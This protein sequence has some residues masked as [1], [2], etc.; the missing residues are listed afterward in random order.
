VFL[1]IAQDPA[2]YR[3]LMPISLV[4]KAFGLAVVVLFAQG[5]APAPVLATGLIDLALGALFLLAYV[6]TR[7]GTRTMQSPDDV[8]RAY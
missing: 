2:R 4:E 1:L 6:R 8:A 3:T 5:R 7:S